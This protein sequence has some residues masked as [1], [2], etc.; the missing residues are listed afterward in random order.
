[1]KQAMITKS[2]LIT[3]EEMADIRYN[4]ARIIL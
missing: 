2:K 3:R 4:Q 1:M